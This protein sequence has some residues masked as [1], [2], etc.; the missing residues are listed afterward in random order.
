MYCG[1]LESGLLIRMASPI[2]SRV[3][4]SLRLFSLETLL[5]VGAS[6][7]SSGGSSGVRIGTGE[8]HGISVD[9]TMSSAEYI[10]PLSRD[11]FSAI[12]WTCEDVLGVHSKEEVKRDMRPPWSSS[13]SSAEAMVACREES[14]GSPL[15]LSSVGLPV[16]EP[17]SDD[18]LIRK[19]GGW[20]NAWSN[21][22]VDDG[23]EAMGVLSQM[24]VGVIN[25]L[26]RSALRICWCSETLKGEGTGVE[27]SSCCQ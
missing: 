20:L 5:S 15:D 21:S 3:H 6:T 16:S 7:S 24:T 18:M 25:V 1:R 10:G 9:S 22:N 14:D 12:S 8:S 13:S 19:D 27:K 2:S 26:S 23:V 4:R 17:G 11:L